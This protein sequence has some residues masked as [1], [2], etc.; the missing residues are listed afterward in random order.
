[1]PGIVSHLLANEARQRERERPRRPQSNRPIERPLPEGV[2][3]SGHRYSI[4][5]RVQALT[6]LSLG[7]KPRQVEELIGVK[8]RT[9]RNIL[10]KA[11]E[12]GFDPQHSL[13]IL[14]HHVEDGAKSGR[15]K[16]IT[17]EVEKH[18]ISL[19]VADRAGREKS[20]DVLAYESGISS[21]SA[22][23]I[24]HRNRLNSVKPTRKP[25]LNQQQRKARLEFCLAHQDWT[26]EDWKRV[27]WSDETSVILSRRGSQ[28]VWRTPE[29]VFD[30]T[31]IRPRWKG[32]S[33]FMF[34][35]C[36]TW[37]SQGPCH[38][39][40]PETA[41]QRKEAEKE[42]AQVNEKNEERMKAEW[43]LTAGIGRLGLRNKPGK[44]PQWRFTEQRGKLV[45]K[46]RG[47]VDFYRYIKVSH[48][49]L[50]HS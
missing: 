44:K 27:I 42:L 50:F 15:P 47:G 5:E 49:L 41:P 40:E 28:R 18:L 17:K 6:Y 25:G 45:R 39:W 26:L 9:A 14:E 11:K 13:K 32:F 7:Y 21:S 37:D 19:V 2:V 1:M 30:Y 3:D 38:I 8:E 4:A 48:S 46:G 20:S 24:L 10:T 23:R 35:G 29:D 43:E 36:F 31:S 12:R 16:E 34:W 33:E 22:L